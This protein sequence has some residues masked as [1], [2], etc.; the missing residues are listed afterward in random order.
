VYSQPALIII[1]VV[2]LECQTQLPK[3]LKNILLRFWEW[4]KWKY[5][6]ITVYANVAI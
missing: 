2:E 6:K 5:S 3:R 1:N 4:R